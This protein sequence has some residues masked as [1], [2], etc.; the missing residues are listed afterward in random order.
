MERA[1]AVFYT[2]CTVTFT[3]KKLIQLEA[4]NAVTKIF[5]HISAIVVSIILYILLRNIR[6]IS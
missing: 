5:I 1:D 4:Y 2:E 6:K 3:K